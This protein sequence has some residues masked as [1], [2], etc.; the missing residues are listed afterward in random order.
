MNGLI[1]CA[2]RTGAE[3]EIYSYCCTNSQL[4]FDHAELS[5]ADSSLSSGVSLRL[6]KD[7]RMGFAYTRNIQEPRR[8]V[9]NALVSMKAGAE[10]RFAF[11]NVHPAKHLQSYSAAAEKLKSENLHNDAA[12]YCSYLSSRCDGDIS[13]LT[14]VRLRE[15]RILNSAGLD[16]AWKAS[17]VVAGVGIAGVG[18][19]SLDLGA[20]GSAHAVLSNDKLDS[21]LETYAALKTEVRPR[22][23]KCRVLFMPSAMYAL[24]WRFEMG[25]CARSLVQGIS[26]LAGKE[27]AQVFSPIL[28]LRDCVSDASLPNVRSVDDEGTPCRDFKMVEKGVFRGFYNDL[29]YSARLG[30]EPTGHG[31]RATRWGGDPVALEPTPYPGRFC[32]ERGNKT[33]MELLCEMGEGII[34]FGTL[35]AHSGNLAC[36]D[37]S[38]GLAPGLVVEGGRIVGKA[39]DTMVSGN[40]YDVMRRVAGVGCEAEPYYNNNPPVLLEGVDV[41][42]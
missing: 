5:E 36:G 42:A 12:G 24:L 8:L 41:S 29:A 35:G 28:T 18:G 19:D 4:R 38:I 21:L 33:F 32:F 3:F 16:I 23:G 10:G 26:P 7:G 2:G 27:G 25:G 1:E 13:A 20:V 22:T 37:F 11:R 15:W 30:V 34:V 40:I 14:R 39:K 9:D 6:L 17:E 31:Y